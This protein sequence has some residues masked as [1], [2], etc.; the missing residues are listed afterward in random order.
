MTVP[1]GMWQLGEGVEVAVG[2][3]EISALGL[4][5]SSLEPAAA[6]PTTPLADTPRTGALV[7]PEW[8]QEGLSRSSALLASSW[9]T[10]RPLTHRPIP[11][12]RRPRF[13]G[14]Q[15]LA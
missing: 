8:V 15:E 10:S 5:D 7:G 12:A 14:L 11:L 6:Q 2:V 9:G 3:K 1:G 13:R 4:A